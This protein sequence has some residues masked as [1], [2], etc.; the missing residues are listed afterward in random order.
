MLDPAKRAA[1]TRIRRKKEK[2]LETAPR[3][4]AEDAE[5]DDYGL[6]SEVI[7][8]LT[9]QRQRLR[10]QKTRQKRSTSTTPAKR[11]KIVGDP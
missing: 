6:S 5:D 7:E 8:N 2:R 1:E 3:H 4:V 10:W 11:Q 9:Y